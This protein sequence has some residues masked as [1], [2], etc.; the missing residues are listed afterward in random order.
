MAQGAFSTKVSAWVAET[1]ERRDRVHRESAKRV[2]Q[3]MQRTRSEGGNLRFDTGFLRAS[4]V[5][6]LGDALPAMTFKP[7]GVEQ[8]SYDA[9][10]TNLVI[11]GADTKDPITA[12]YTANYARPREY[13]A[14]GQTPDRFVALA[15]QQWQQIVNQVCAEAQKRA[16]G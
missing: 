7:D 6:T 3:V 5:V 2:I 1:K 8:F 14:K 16:G 4:L 15:A 13:G 10:A 11:A 9:A 12:V